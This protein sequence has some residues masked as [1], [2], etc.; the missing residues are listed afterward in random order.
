MKRHCQQGL[1]AFLEEEVY[2]GK[3]AFRAVGAYIREKDERTY[4]QIQLDHFYES[5]L[6]QGVSEDTPRPCNW[7]EACMGD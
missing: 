6:D 3:I 7:R 2:K 4:K 5:L 1:C